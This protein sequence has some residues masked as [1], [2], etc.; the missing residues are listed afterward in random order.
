ML[1]QSIKGNENQLEKKKNENNST[2]HLKPENGPK[3]WQQKKIAS[4]AADANEK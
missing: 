3:N 4:A 1:S 2:K